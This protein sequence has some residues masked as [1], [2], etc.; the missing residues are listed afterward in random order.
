MFKDILLP[1][2]LTHR[3]TQL[4]AVGNAADMARQW[5]STLHVITILPDF[6]MSIVGSYF[7]KGFEEKALAE[8]D[9]QLHEFT[10]KEIGTDIKIHRIVG[11]GTI[12]KEIMHYA[13]ETNCD[14]IV[15][16]SHRPELSDYL[17]GP[18]AAR[19]VRHAKQSV[20]VVRE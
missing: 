3:E 1:V 5:G 6:G 4:K 16:A 13:N 10:D 11:S 19:V 14:L 17:L 9:K 2:D 20:L 18:N 15:M 12:Y 7:P 8:A